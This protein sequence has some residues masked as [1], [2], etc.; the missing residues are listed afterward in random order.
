MTTAL[1]LETAMTLPA[2]PTTMT[3]REIAELTGKEHA[4]VMRD[5]RSMLAEL[6]L[7]E[8]GYI[9]NWRHPQN[10]QVYEEFALPK[11]LTITL[12]SGY[13]VSMRHRIV[14]RWQE[15]EAGAAHRIPQ[16]LPE[17]LRLAAD[18]ADEITKK[19]AQ[20]ALIAPKAAALDR[21]STQ[22]NGAVCMRT[23]AKLVQVPEKQFLRFLNDE[24]WIFRHHRSNTWQGYAEK[25]KA[26]LLELK[27]TRVVHGDGFEKTF[28]QVLITPKGLAKAAELIERKV[29][30]LR[31]AATFAQEVNAA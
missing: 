30:W 10:C 23:A 28:E 17:A 14:S 9:Q 5:A 12:V 6:S 26:G 4:H 15:L 31:K 3:S 22:T 13:S 25:E 21:I 7:A 19:D 20:L 27:R 29:P 11:D 1:V 8:G 18:M 24:G 16:T 2:A